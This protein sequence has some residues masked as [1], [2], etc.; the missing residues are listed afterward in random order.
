MEINACR[1]KH[2]AVDKRLDGHDT[3]IGV[4]EKSDAVNSAEIKNLGKQIGSQTK[5]IWGLVSGIFFVMFGFLIWY[6][7]T[8][9]R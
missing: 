2:E 7:Q 8:L 9:P 3:R 5:A 4:L 1:E 6:V